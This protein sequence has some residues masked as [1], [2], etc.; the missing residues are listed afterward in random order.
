[1][2]IICPKSADFRGDHAVK[3]AVASDGLQ[4]PQRPLKGLKTV[5]ILSANFKAVLHVKIGQVIHILAHLSKSDLTGRAL[6]EAEEKFNLAINATDV[7]K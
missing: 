1:M 6:A 3:N 2:K 7:R 4:Q 5:W